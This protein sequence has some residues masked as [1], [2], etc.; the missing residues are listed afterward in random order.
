M[1]TLCVLIAGVSLVSAAQAS[2]WAQR[3]EAARLA[4]EQHDY[5]TA[6]RL[7]SESVALATTAAERESALASYGIALSSGGRNAEARPVL[8]QALAG[9]TGDESGRRV[10]VAG[11]LA[12]VDR[13][14]GDYQSAE[15]ILRAAIGDGTASQG[16]RSILMVNLAD[17]M[18]E[19]ARAPEAAQ[20]LDEAT[21]LKGLTEPQRTNILVES[22]ELNR[23]L[24]NW[25]ASVSAWNRIGEIAEQEHSIQFEE[26]FTSGLGET[27]LAA[28]QTARAE[29]LLRR[30]LQLLQND[31]M[32]S[33]AQIAMALT[34]MAGVYDAENKLALAC[35]AI[36]EA[37]AKYE[38]A[39]G[40]DHPQ[41]AMLLQVQADILSKRGETERARAVLE[42]AR[43][44]MTDHFG[45]ESRAV[46]GVL[47]GMADLEQRAK[48]PEAAIGEYTAAMRLLSKSGADMAQYRADLAT[49]YAAALRA[50]HRPDEASAVLANAQSFVS[51]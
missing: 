42:R 3:R 22:A 38:V 44:I 20:L 6:A 16:D 17:M 21:R 1:R 23:D 45:E 39:L 12:S 35:E 32:A 18:R 10:V 4:V 15:R 5:N 50:A 13:N 7:Y 24:H 26:S 2:E 36:N 19:E 40:R 14:L 34:L 49:R 51:K 9:A 29:P 11:T 31:P 41:L 27:W 25:D 8:E 28:G 30:S 47:V 48:R 33:D 46:A 37:I 43:L